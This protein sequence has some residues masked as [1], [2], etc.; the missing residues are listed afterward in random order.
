MMFLLIEKTINK[1]AQHREVAY[2]TNTSMIFNETATKY[3][4]LLAITHKGLAAEM[5]VITKFIPMFTVFIIYYIIFAFIKFIFVDLLFLEWLVM[6]HP[7]MRSLRSGVYRYFALLHTTSLSHYQWKH[8]REN[9]KYTGIL[10]PNIVNFSCLITLKLSLQC[11]T[12]AAQPSGILCRWG[13]TGNCV[14]HH[15]VQ[16]H[17]GVQGGPLT[18]K[19]SALWC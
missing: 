15:A 4:L 10:I 9:G 1:F 18:V 6:C 19:Y 7:L 2:R 5:V 3:Y 17:K 13:S 14:G 12:Q 16:E 11:P 8:R